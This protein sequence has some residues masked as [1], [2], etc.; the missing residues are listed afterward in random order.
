MLLLW[1]A[2]LLGTVFSAQAFGGDYHFT[3]TTPGSDSKQA[4]DL[5]ESNFSER[6]GDDVNVVFQTR[7]GA[8]VDDPAVRAEIEG[9]LDQFGNEPHVSAVVSPFTPEGAHQ[10]APTRTIT[11]GTLH[12]D[13]TVSDY[14]K[15][16]AQGLLSLA[17][18]VERPDLQVE[19]AGFVLGD[20]ITPRII[21]GAAVTMLGVVLVALA[22]RRFKAVSPAPA[23]A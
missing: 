21:T 10:I 3:F 1:V 6:A 8:K 4:Q 2:V 14:K 15:A 7:Q 18:K 16:D 20:H 17:D 11:Y 23:E 13:Q 19:L 9:T 12:L 22:E 5:L